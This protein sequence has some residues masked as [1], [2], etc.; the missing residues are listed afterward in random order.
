MI[1]NL[2]TGIGKGTEAVDELTESA[3]E[4]QA[5]L[6]K[7]HE[8]DMNSD[9]WLSKS[10]RPMSLIWLF[11]LETLIVVLDATG[12]T[13]DTDTKVQVG[14]LL[15]AA[16]GFYFTSRKNEKIAAKNA[17]ANIKMEELKLKHSQKLERK[18]IRAERRAARRAERKQDKE[19]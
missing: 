17:T 9:N 4:R 1:R 8:T 7:R 18:E 6:T 15:L 11:A 3:E 14:A 12:H 16:F 19:D 13:V 5:A 10:I 2:I